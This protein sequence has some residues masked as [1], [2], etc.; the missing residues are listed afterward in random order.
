MDN[1]LGFIGEMQKKLDLEISHDQLKIFFFAILFLIENRKTAQMTP[2]ATL[3]LLLVKTNFKLGL[4]PQAIREVRF[5][6]G[7]DS[8]SLEVQNTI[9]WLKIQ[10][11]TNLANEQTNIRSL[12]ELENLILEL[13]DSELI[14]S[15]LYVL[16]SNAF[17]RLGDANRSQCLRTKAQVIAVINGGSN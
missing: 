12:I 11:K 7:A 14:D 2:S 17:G 9:D 15:E 4:I 6:Y 13:E 8:L 16:I 5:A 10:I 1:S 3:H